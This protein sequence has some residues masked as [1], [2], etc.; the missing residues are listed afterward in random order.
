MKSS[1]G[2][3]PQDNLYRAVYAAPVP[4]DLPLRAIT[5]PEGGTGRTLDVQWSVFDQWTEIDSWYEGNFME[6]IAPGA[7]S[8]TIK[9]NKANMRI[10]LQHGGDPQIGDKPIATIDEVGENDIGGYGRGELF[11][12]LDPLVVDGL[13]AGV[14]GASFRFRVMRDEL[15]QEPDPSD[16]N[17]RG[18]PERTIREAGVQEFGPVTWGAYSQASSG[19][20]SLTDEMHFATLRDMPEARLN[21]LVNFWKARDL[22]RVDAGDLSHLGQMIVCATEYIAEQDEPDEAENVARMNEVLTILS[23]LVTFEA[24][25]VEP[26]EADDEY[27]SAPD[28]DME[29]RRTE[30]PVEAPTLE[31]T[32]TTVA[33]K[34][35]RRYLPAGSYRKRSTS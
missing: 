18:I 26:A 16:Y 33:K 14:Y 24:A 15:N 5:V 23:T 12:G 29:S 4:G 6:R 9:E 13:R 19:V 7:F 1:R 22:N 3:L 21:A 8:K 11:P 2:I 20:R 25:E 31:V 28:S 27:N 10:L 32:P 34:P 17:P 30:A 35:A